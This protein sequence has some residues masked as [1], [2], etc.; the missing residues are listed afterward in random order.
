M[1]EY[2]TGNF[3]IRSYGCCVMQR[4]EAGGSVNVYLKCSLN[5]IVKVFRGVTSALPLGKT[6]KIRG[7]QQDGIRTKYSRFGVVQKR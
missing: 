5:I 4:R 6:G 2:G 7:H 1:H 3:E